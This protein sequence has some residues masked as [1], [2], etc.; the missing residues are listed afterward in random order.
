MPDSYTAFLRLHY[1]FFDGRCESALPAA[2]LL[3][4]LVLASVRTLEAA[5][6]AFALVTLDFANLFTSLQG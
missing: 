3:V 2:V 5:L 1:F 6:A 4:L